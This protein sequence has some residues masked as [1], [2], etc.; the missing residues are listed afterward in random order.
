MSV[1]NSAIF[2]K[3]PFDHRNMRLILLLGFIIIQSKYVMANFANPNFEHTPLDTSPTYKNI[4]LAWVEDEFI[5]RY[6]GKEVTDAVCH[7]NNVY[8]D[9]G[10][11]F[12]LT[13]FQTQVSN[14]SI[15]SF[16]NIEVHENTC[17]VQH[18]IQ[19]IENFIKQSSTTIFPLI[20]AT[21]SSRQ[22]TVLKPFDNSVTYFRKLDFEWEDSDGADQYLLEL[23]LDMNF[24]VPYLSS[25]IFTTHCTVEDLPPNQ[26][27]YWRIKP[28]NF[29]HYCEEHRASGKTFASKTFVHPFNCNGISVNSLAPP[30]ATSLFV[31]NPENQAYTLS[32]ES[33]DESVVCLLETNAAQKIIDVSHYTPGAY[34]V[35]LS[36][37]QFKN[38]STLIIE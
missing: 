24:N 9:L 6:C 38:S 12:S 23:S 36:A 8:K 27:I 5:S 16:F 30:R 17:L 20:P 13:P 11:L 34:F 22:M 31:H 29:L 1:F 25:I 7:I 35:Y 26:M 3:L 18:D 2:I 10:Y 32:I 33:M 15:K 28:L 37:G 14:P 19:N 4:P 21:P